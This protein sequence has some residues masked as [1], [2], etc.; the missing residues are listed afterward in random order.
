[1]RVPRPF[2]AFLLFAVCGTA[3]A[4]EPFDCRNG[5]FPADIDAISAGRIAAVAGPRVRLRADDEGCPEAERCVQKAYLVP[6]DRVLVSTRDPQWACVWYS[7]RKR[8]TVGWLPAS[9]VEAVVAAVPELQAWVGR[10]RAVSGDNEIEIRSVGDRLAVTGD[11]TWQGVASVNVGQF[12]GEGM[13]EGDRWIVGDVA[14]E[15]ECA[16]DM[17]LVA[18]QLVVHDNGNC[19]GLN[20]RFDHVYR[21]AR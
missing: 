12:E 1:M 2:P 21:K 15:Y 4:V 14:V 20:V 5:L 10:W 17:R 13:P 7:G 11:A 3:A 9:A 6:G 19:G 16:V 8:E 18:G